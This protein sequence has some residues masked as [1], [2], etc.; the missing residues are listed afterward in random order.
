MFKRVTHFA[1]ESF[2]PRATVL[3]LPSYKK[4]NKNYD[5]R[6]NRGKTGTSFMLRLSSTPRMLGLVVSP[7]IRALEEVSEKIMSEHYKMELT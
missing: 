4:K 6:K 3:P 2:L 1:A 7:S 5:K